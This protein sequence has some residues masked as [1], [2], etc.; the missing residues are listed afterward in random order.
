MNR[1]LYGAAQS[2]INQQRIF[3]CISNNVTNI[4]TAGYRKDEIVLSTFRE[5]LY[6]IG[7]RSGTS[8]TYY[9]T[10]VDTSKTN[11]DQ[12][13]FSIT[14]SPFDLGIYG[15]MYFNV[16]Y[17][18]D[19]EIYQTRNGQWGLDR[20]GYLWLGGVGRVQGENGDIYIGNDDFTVDERGI[21]TD[22]NGQVI[23]TLLFTYIPDGTDVHKEGDSLF[24]YEGEPLEIPQDEWEDFAVIQGA[25]E[26]SNVDPI[27]E[28]TQA[29][30]A[31]RMYEASS[32]IFRGFDSMNQK[33]S[34]IS[35]L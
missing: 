23:D 16:R 24:L 35:E 20:E 21:I 17:E 34:S 25:Y 11:L 1:G 3:D 18:K 13:G 32:K 33:S 28:M 29:M 12:G 30:E 9:Q 4:N 26:K 2:M 27:K 5:Q 15:N 31:H 8:G 19:G 10:Y 6:L 22:E 14:N 7:H